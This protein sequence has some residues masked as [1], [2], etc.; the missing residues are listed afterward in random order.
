M[1]AWRECPTPSSSA[2][3]GSAPNDVLA[4][5]ICWAAQVWECCLC[6]RARRQHRW[7]I[8][9]ASA[10][11]TAAARPIASPQ[12]CDAGAPATQVVLV[13]HP[14]MDK[15]ELVLVLQHASQGT[16][17]D[18]IRSWRG[19]YNEVRPRYYFQQLICA[20]RHCHRQGIA[21]RDL[22]LE[23]AFVHLE[24][25]PGPTGSTP[26]AVL[27]LGDFGYG[28]HMDWHTPP[29]TGLGTKQYHSPVRS[30]P[31]DAPWRLRVHAHA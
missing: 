13:Q 16:L 27:K 12:S 14:A 31:F 10:S 21:H 23:N 2:S 24:Q 26:T 6:T 20:V 19:D 7:C 18:M 15:S 3:S 1:R 11:S 8:A 30:L 25:L 9:A 22:K 5:R 28:K 29:D 17:D 4:Y